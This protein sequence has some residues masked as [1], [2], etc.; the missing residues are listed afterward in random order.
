MLGLKKKKSFGIRMTQRF[1][2]VIDM[3]HFGFI[4]N[5]GMKKKI[6]F[7]RLRGTDLPLWDTLRKYGKGL[8]SALR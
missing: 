6:T 5:F 4:K 2:K 1:T 8:Q 3:K 7:W